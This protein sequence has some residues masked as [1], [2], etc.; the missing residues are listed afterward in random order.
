MNKFEILK[1]LFKMKYNPVGVKLIFNEKDIDNVN[2]K[3]PKKPER[4]CEFVKKAALG[5][6]LKIKKGEF[7][8]VTA[9]IMLGFKKTEHIEL[10]MTLGMRGLKYILLFPLNKYI[11]DDFD[12]VILIVTPRNCMDLVEAYVKIYNKPLKPSFGSVFG[13]CSEI[14]AYVIKRQE[15][16]FSFLCT[17]S[18]IYAGF[19]D[20]ELICGVPSSMIFEIIDELELII[21]DRE[22]DIKLLK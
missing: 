13:V 20:C 19:D 6:F 18:R 7:S 14:T 4:Y 11:P 8:C 22:A 17:G 21:K 1:D 5:E 10:K 2:F 9:E 12:S 16:N 15:I 3:T